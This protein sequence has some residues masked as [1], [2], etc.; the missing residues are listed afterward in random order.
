MTLEMAAFIIGGLVLLFIGGE[1]LV[2]GSVAAARKLGVSELVIGLT[3]VGFGTSVP[4]LVTSLQAMG[5]GAV[6]ISVG[7]VFGSNIANVLLVLGMAAVVCPFVTNPRAI[8][9]DGIF[10]VAVTM[11]FAALIWFDLFTRV[12][13]II[14]IVML[15]VYMGG[16]ILLDRKSNSPASV[17]IADE[18]EAIEIHAPLWLALIMTVGGIAGVIVGAKLLVQGGS[19]LARL[20]GISET[21]IGLSIVAIGTSL[22]ELVTSVMSALKGKADVALGNVIGSNIFNILGIMGVTA[23]VYPF[24]VRTPTGDGVAVADSVMGASVVSVQDLVALA[25]SV[26]LLVVFAFTGRKIGRVE[27]GIL[28]FGYAAFMALTFGL[29][30]GFGD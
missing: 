30:P 25:V 21:V 19:D 8:M 16:S 6:G 4:E 15:V 3:L 17:L 7:N 5:D 10:M 18:A 28:L 23:T 29:V 24:T 14:L 12:T 27:G 2:R 9:R 1:A 11:L 20:F 26:I 13:G 22:P